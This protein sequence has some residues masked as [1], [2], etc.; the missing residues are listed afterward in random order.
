ME[1]ETLLGLKISINL[2]KMSGIVKLEFI[3]YSE[4]NVIRYVIYL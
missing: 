4:N 1:F 2:I 3:N